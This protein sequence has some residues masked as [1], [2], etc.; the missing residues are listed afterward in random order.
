MT[1]RLVDAGWSRE[2]TQAVRAGAGGLLIISP[3]I[4]TGALARLLA[5]RPRIVSVITRFNLSDFAEGVSDIAALRRLLKCGAT[6]RGVRNLHS[7]MYLFGSERAI[8]TSA[9]LTEAALDRNQEFGLVSGERKIVAARQRY[10]D[11]LWRRS[12]ADLTIPQ[13]DLWDGVVTLYRAEGGRPNPS[14][15]L[16]D[17]GADAGMVHPPPTLLPIVFA[18]WPQAF[19]KFLG[20]GD[21]RVPLSFPTLEQIKLSGCHWA[22]AYPDAKRPR[23]VKDDAVIFIAD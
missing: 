13:L 12:G 16:G 9:N 15:E 18:D 3:F 20:E 5:G 10:F 14:T 2:L 22:V 1:T 21:N 8:V 6:V 19:V 23:S 7:K 11:D 17:L 4:K